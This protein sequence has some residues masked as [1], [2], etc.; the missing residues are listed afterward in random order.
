VRDGLGAAAERRQQAD[1]R[2]DGRGRLALCEETQFLIWYFLLAPKSFIPGKSYK[3]ISK[4]FRR[5]I[6]LLVGTNTLN[7]FYQ[8]GTNHSFKQRIL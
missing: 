8:D 2:R 6:H 5:F 1:G 4:K 3:T 7:I